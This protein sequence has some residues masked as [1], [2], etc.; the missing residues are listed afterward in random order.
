MFEKSIIILDS[1][2]ELPHVCENPLVIPT[3]ML[4]LV[5]LLLRLYRA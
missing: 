4:L 5:A 1:L 2:E 3:N